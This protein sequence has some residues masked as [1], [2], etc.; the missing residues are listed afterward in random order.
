MHLLG[1]VLVNGMNDKWMYTGNSIEFDLV[2][3]GTQLKIMRL[4]KMNND[5]LF[6]WMT[7]YKV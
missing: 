3:I 2:S 1:G 4:Q 6:G 5:F 7:D